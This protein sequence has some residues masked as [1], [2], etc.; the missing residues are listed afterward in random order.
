MPAPYYED[1]L[2]TLYLGD[3]RE[4]T[5]WLA[6]DVLVTDPPYGRDWSSGSLKAAQ[7]G[8]HS[9]GRDGIAGDSDTAVRDQA[10]AMW[11]DRLAVVFGDLILA[12]PAGNKQALVYQKPPDAGVAWSGGRIP[13][14]CRGHLPD[15]PMADRARWPSSVL[16][17]RENR[18]SAGAGRRRATDTLTPS[19]ST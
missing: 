1:D 8:G 17:D 4:V 12:P 9:S 15:R 6:A 14:R 11:G 19:R 10:L 5:D 18:G 2:V 16:C 13:A 3:C 7:G